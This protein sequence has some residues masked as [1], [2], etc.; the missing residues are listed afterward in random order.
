MIIK[1]KYRKKHLKQKPG[2]PVTHVDY[3]SC[4]Y[5]KEWRKSK[6]RERFKTILPLEQNLKKIRKIQFGLHKS[7]LVKKNNIKFR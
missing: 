1:N 4:I 7:T 5:S 6:T 2:T 3:P